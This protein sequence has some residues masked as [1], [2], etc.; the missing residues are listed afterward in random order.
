MINTLDDLM[1]KQVDIKN[2]E[3]NFKAHS[4]R[5]DFLLVDELSSTQ[6][7]LSGVS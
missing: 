5:H 3:L 7:F 6:V 1:R 2:Q 4:I